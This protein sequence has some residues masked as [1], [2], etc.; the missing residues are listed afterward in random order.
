MRDPLLRTAVALSLFEGALLG[1][2]FRGQGGVEYWLLIAVIVAIVML[3]G[4]LATYTIARSRLPPERV[5]GLA[6][7][8]GAF[9]GFVAAYLV[10][11]VG[12]PV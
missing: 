3:V 5:A 6:F 8:V 2:V 4:S 11:P 12:G 9:A 10:Q 7:F 1:Y